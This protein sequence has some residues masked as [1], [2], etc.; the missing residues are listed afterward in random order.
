VDRR[1]PVAVVTLNQP[2]ARN[3]LGTENSAALHDA[4]KA[5]AGDRDIRTVVLTGGGGAF[6]AGAD[7]REGFPPDQRI[8]DV[9][10]TRYSPSLNLIAGMDQPVIAA[11][12]G[13]AAGIGMSFALA[14][15]LI[16]MAEDGFLL[17]PFSTIGLLPDG[18]ATWFLVR[19]LG[20]HLAYQLCVEAERIPAAR[21]LE[22]GLVNRVVPAAGL[23]DQAVGWAEDLARRAPLSM[24]ATKH[25]MRQAMHFSL[26]ES[27]ALEARLQTACARSADAQEGVSAFMEKRKPVFKGR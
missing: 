12:A 23:L 7:L 10:H 26:A 16:V 6:S 15:D 4:L 13:P 2:A 9:I 24:A 20:Y 21:C 1:G 14:C 11:V 17:A 18:G 25:A 19:R 22:L 8:E 5:A 27:M 3:A